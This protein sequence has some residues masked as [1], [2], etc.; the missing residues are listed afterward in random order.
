MKKLLPALFLVVAVTS[1]VQAKDKHWDKH[2]DRD[3]DHDKHSDYERRSYDQSRSYRSYSTR[4]NRTRT[5]YIIERDRPVARTVFV[6]P[7][8]R[9][10]RRVNGR[11][12][13]VTQHYFESYPSR[14]YTASGHRRITVRLPF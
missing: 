12:S 7:D 3:R 10:Y 2:H 13:Y 8:G 9:Y 5:I 6:G 4:Q 11:R 14:Y 1:A